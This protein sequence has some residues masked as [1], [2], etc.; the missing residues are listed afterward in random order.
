MSLLTR[1][2]KLRG[3]FDEEFSPS[4][5][6]E[7]EMKL[8]SLNFILI[9]IID[10]LQYVYPEPEKAYLTQDL[11][12]RA[13]FV[14]DVYFLAKSGLNVT[15]MAGSSVTL[16]DKIIHG[17]SSD[18]KLGSFIKM[19]SEKVEEVSLLPILS[20]EEFKSALG[21]L[22]LSE[23]YPNDR[24]VNTFYMK[25]GGIIRRMIM[26][27][28]VTLPSN[29]MDQESLIQVL[30]L[31][32]NPYNSDPFNR[33]RITE[34]ELFQFC[35]QTEESFPLERLKIWCDEGYLFNENGYYSCLV[36]GY[37][38]R[39]FEITVDGLSIAEMRA[40]ANPVGAAGVVLEGIIVEGKTESLGWDKLPLTILD[41]SSIKKGEIQSL[42][43]KIMKPVISGGVDK[44]G[45]GLSMESLNFHSY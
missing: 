29:I 24:D 31:F 30:M 18:V 39:L 14:R 28:D 34:K 27:T 16:A 11:E 19:N 40:F 10:E 17:I 22:S 12:E 8:K 43:R 23:A 7:F 26:N 25:T 44:I 1:I 2:G 13:N 35:R 36:Y 33:K 42:C 4:T 37:V 5:F 41:M 32:Y 6:L 20:K 9:L 45:F 15:I 38:A 3:I 21:V